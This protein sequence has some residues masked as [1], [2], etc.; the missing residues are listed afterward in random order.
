MTKRRKPH[1]PAAATELQ[2]QRMEIDRLKAQG[3]EVNVDDRTGKLLSARRSNIFNILLN[4][5]SISQNEHDAAMRFARLWAAWKGCDG[6]GGHAEKVD[7]GSGSAELVTDRQIIAGRHIDGILKY[8]GPTSRALIKA[9]MYD[10]VERCEVTVWRA[11]VERIT[12]IKGRDA[13]T[14]PVIMMCK[15]LCAV[16]EAP[17]ARVAA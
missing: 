8:L 16:M 7:G 1:N 6:G 5:G 11:T 12:G 4:A 2:L 3:A 10:Y 9:F 17:K 14:A 13:Q 15:D